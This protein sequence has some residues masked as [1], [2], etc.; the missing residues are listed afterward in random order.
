MSTVDRP[1][2]QAPLP[3]VDGERMT[4]A[5]FRRRDA[6]LPEGKW[7]ELIGGIVHMVFGAHFEHATSDSALGAW[8]YVYT[9]S[10]PGV[11]SATNL[12]TV[13]GD[14]TEVQPDQ[15]LLIPEALGGRSRLVGG[16]VIGPPEL[17]VEVSQSTRSKDLGPKK[18]QYEK[19]GVAEY[20]FIGLGPDEAR[21]FALADGRYEAIAPEADGS[22]RSRAFPGLWL[23]PK[24]LL[25]GDGAAMFAAL[26]RGLASPEHARFVAELAGRGGR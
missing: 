17:V 2:I 18:A 7:A 21:W 12:S 9:Q 26:G 3:L 19:A 8:L 22:L 13:L 1:G 10:T 11:L 25:A 5:E 23:D 14:D 15:Q 16:K 20:L 24:A 6:L 4:H